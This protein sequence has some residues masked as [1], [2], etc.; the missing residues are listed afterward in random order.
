MDVDRGNGSAAV[1]GGA[2]GD[3]DGGV[4]DGFR[5]IVDGGAEGGFRQCLLCMLV[6]KAK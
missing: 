5:E 6:L 4:E 1:G 2:D 3:V